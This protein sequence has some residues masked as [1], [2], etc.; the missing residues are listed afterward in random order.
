MM[1]K[2]LGLMAAVLLLTGCASGMSPVGYALITNVDGPITATTNTAGSKKGSSC[3]T[4]ILGLIASGDA[5]I[6]TAKRN[7]GITKLAT[8]DYSSSGIY[9]IFGQT[10]TNVTGE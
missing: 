7:G 6:A 3:V 5:S 8:A 9:P 4:N 1:K 10:C 2:T